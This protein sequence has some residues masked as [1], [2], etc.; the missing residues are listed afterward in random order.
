MALVALLFLQPAQT[1]LLLL[2]KSLLFLAELFFA[3]AAHLLRVVNAIKMRLI[4]IV[5]IDH[6]VTPLFSG[7]WW[8]D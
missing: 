1:L 6:D 7:F 8:S 2:P 5:G 3:I 4:R